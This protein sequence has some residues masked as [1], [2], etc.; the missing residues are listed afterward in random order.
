[1]KTNIFGILEKIEKE[2]NLYGWPI[3]G[4][5]KGRV[6][7][8]EVLETHPKNILEIGVLVGYSS[9]LMGQYLKDG[10]K[11]TGIEI[12]P[13]A[14]KVARKNIA[15]ANLEDRVDIKVGD[16]LKIIPKLEGP[17]DL[18][19]LDAD[20]TEYLDYLKLL[21]DKLSDNAVI[22]ADN[23]KVFKDTLRNYIKYVENHFNSRVID[24]GF[25]SVEVSIKKSRR[26]LVEFNGSILPLSHPAPP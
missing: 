13:N 20:K 12:N 16:A 18:V 25:D 24:F 7:T 2:A 10:E 5:Q 17:F 9:I 14:A 4:L 8:S 19:F 21:E 15:L 26:S 11:I 1:M 6:L 22:I 3:I 23:I